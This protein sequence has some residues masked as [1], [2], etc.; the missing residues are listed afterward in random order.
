MH[1]QLNSH[2]HLGISTCSS[3]CLSVYLSVGDSE[4]KLNIKE[5]TPQSTSITS[6][7]SHRVH[8]ALQPSSPPALQ[9][10]S[11]VLPPLPPYRPLSSNSIKHR[12]DPT[13]KLHDACPC[14][15][16][17]PT[18]SLSPSLY[19]RVTQ[20]L[21]QEPDFKRSCRYTWT[22]TWIWRGR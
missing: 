6:I 12:S 22:W 4:S 18:H 9:P 19:V 8:P 17:C 15:S 16:S 20:H 2:L 13:K 3:R 7:A 1:L 10:S 5:T 14:T 11:P 21:H